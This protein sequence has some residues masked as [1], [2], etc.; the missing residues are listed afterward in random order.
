MASGF[1]SRRL[2]M[3]DSIE[4]AEARKRTDAE[5]A[6]LCGPI[7]DEVY[8]AAARALHDRHCGPH[9]CPSGP[10]V[11]EVL[12]AQT[13]TETVWP[14][15]VEQGRREACRAADVDGTTL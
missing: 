13:V 6:A 5:Q 11:D 1:G 10:L 15:A 9:D 2:P 8:E 4:H 7:P 14:L 3:P 12:A